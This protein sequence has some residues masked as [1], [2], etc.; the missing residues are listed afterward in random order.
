MKGFVF[1]MNKCV[2]CHACVV[3]CSVENDLLPP[4]ERRK[5]YAFN[6]IKHPDLPVFNLS[7]ACNHCEEASCMDACPSGAYTRDLQTGAVLLNEDNC[8]ACGYCTW[9][10][11]YDAPQLNRES[12]LIDKCTLCNEKVRGGG[13]PACALNCPTGALDYKEFVEDGLFTDQTGFPD[14][15]NKPGIRFIPK[16]TSNPPEIAP[17]PVS[18]RLN[19]LNKKDIPLPES[20]ISLI[21]EWPLVIF[22]LIVPLLTGLVSGFVTGMIFMKWWLYVLISGSAL[23]LSTMHLGRKK[24]M[25]YAVRNWKTSWLSR[26]IIS[27]G[28]FFL[29]SVLF[30]MLGYAYFWLGTVAVVS[31]LLCTFSM[32]KV[33]KYFQFNSSSFSLGSSVLLTALMWISLA[34]QETGPLG[35]II[36]I[37]VILYIRKKLI[38]DRNSILSLMT[39]V[40]RVSLLVII[41]AFLHVYSEEKLWYLFLPLFA[42]EIIDRV[43]FF[44]LGYIDSPGQR[45]YKLL[46]N[47]IRTGKLK[48]V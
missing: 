48:R 7:L 6:E 19:Y 22:T 35:F 29:T 45:M 8:M 21:N 28:L 44:T 41:P 4:V 11:P 20:K 34:Q 46:L 26:E 1:D 23:L 30:V 5:I 42:G 10:C 18:G 14:T 9:A 13:K 27:Y 39:S 3:A 31:G 12:G 25:V 40:L 16:R 33:Y 24:R 32:D 43:E 47:M 36:G 2:A 37:K 17:V 15:K 38:Y